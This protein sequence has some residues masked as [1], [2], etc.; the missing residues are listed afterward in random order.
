LA[1]VLGLPAFFL[2]YSA[3]RSALS[4]SASASSSSSLPKRST[5]SSSS[6]AAAA[7]ADEAP[8]RNDSPAVLEPESD[9]NSA[10]YDLIWVY[11]RATWGFDAA[12][13][14]DEIA[15]KT[16]TSAW[17]GVYL[18]E[19]HIRDHPEVGGEMMRGKGESEG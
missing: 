19:M 10:V 7:G 13:G 5:S 11:H 16:T 12:L 9:A 17:E 4:F 3:T 6:A 2:V 15:L 8:P 1:T 18:G 14:A